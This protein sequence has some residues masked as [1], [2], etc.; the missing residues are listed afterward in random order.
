MRGRSVFGYKSITAMRLSGL[1]VALLALSLTACNPTP[2]VPPVDVSALKK[3]PM[4]VHIDPEMD[5]RFRVEAVTP[6]LIVPTLQVPGRIEANE[7]L[8]TRIGAAVTGRVT[9]VLV[10]AG[11]R[12]TAG[13]TL[14]K[15]ASPELSQTQMAYLRAHS[16]AAL[17]ER[18]VERAR[19]LYQADVIGSAELQRRESELSMARA[20][21]RALGD[22]LKLMGV[23]SHAI[24][25]LRDQGTLQTV[26][27]ILSPQS[28]VVI[29]RKASNGQVAQPGD[30]L[31]TVADL[32]H[33]W[34]I[35]AL[36]EQTAKAVQVGQWVDIEVPAL[37]G[38]K[39]T[40]KIIH[41]GDTVSPET[42]TVSIRT[43]V[44]NAKRD[45]KPQM[46]AYLR[47]RG[48]ERRQLVIPHDAVIRENDQDY[49]YTRIAQGQYR[50]NR[51]ELENSQNE[52]R[53]VLKGL[54]ENDQVVTQ[55]AFHL[56]NERKRT[57]LQ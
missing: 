20:E 34:V 21:S 41:V 13:Q 16:S 43:Q 2:S 9:E 15:M 10:D 44:E 37:D 27:H 24:E 22:Q 5:K 50:L 49:V 26:G 52:M 47:I 1:C 55:G 18:A 38:R 36:P 17:A 42:R 3:D 45:L 54:V 31:F 8:V 53:P 6:A 12:I 19:L 28:G 11:D 30:H 25:N 57:E 39:M 51:V 35:G 29:E 7:R 32:G 48:E 56:H 46:L 14:A 4:I 23:A 33:V 40:G